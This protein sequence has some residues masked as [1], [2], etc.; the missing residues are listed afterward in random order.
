M[1][2]INPVNIS[3]P[4]QTEYHTHISILLYH[5]V[6][7]KPN[8]HTNL[9]C[10]CD[11]QKFRTQMKF[12]KESNYQVVSLNEAL[13]LIFKRKEIVA[14]YVVLTFDD[15][16]EQFYDITHPILEEFDFPST[17]YPVTGFLGKYAKWGKIKHPYLKILTKE[18]LI[19]LSQ[20]GVEIGA[21]TVYHVKLTQ[22][23]RDTALNQ[24]KNSKDSLEQILGKK[25]NSFAYPHGDFNTDVTEVVNKAGFGNALTCINDYA[26][27]AKSIFEIPR[28]YITH[29]D[30]LNSFKQKLA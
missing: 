7:N 22:V 30:D 25:I 2:K 1:K 14:K 21:H 11:V 10:F 3:N 13:D 6:G 16:C 4:I 28:K 29:A 18:K 8:Q 20:L 17:I 9:D 15:G 19:E 5:Q 27:K 24:V 26:E 23:D 12:L